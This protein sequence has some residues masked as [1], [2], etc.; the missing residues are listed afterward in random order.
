VKKL[1][2]GQKEKV[3]GVQKPSPLYISGLLRLS[4][5]KCYEVKNDLYDQPLIAKLCLKLVKKVA[6][7]GPLIPFISVNLVGN[8][9]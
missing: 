9:S 5:C 7:I 1:I 2:H 4:M 6:P 8:K 3:L